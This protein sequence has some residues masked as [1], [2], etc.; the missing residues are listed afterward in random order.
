MTVAAVASYTSYVGDGV[1]TTFPY[2]FLVLDAAHLQVFVAGVATASFTV[3]GVGNPAG[4]Q[5]IFAG[6]PPLGAR[7]QIYRVMPLDQVTSYFEGDPFPA[8]AHERAL[9]RLVLQLQQLE[10]ALGRTLGVDRTAPE[11][12]RAVALPPPG[13][14]TLLGWNADGSALSTYDPAIVQVTVDPVSGRATGKT[15]RL[16]ASADGAPLLTAA[17]VFAAGS[18][19]L[20]VTYRCTTT[21]STERGLT[22]IDLGMLGEGDRWGAGVGRT[23]PTLSN[24]GQWRNYRPQPIVDLTD[25]TL[26]PRGGS[27]GAAGACTITGHWETYQADL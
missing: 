4:G 3:T 7:L 19:A 2:P 23:A 10:E 22:G 25:V 6:P 27:F 15:T 18:L 24:C 16:V 1:Q 26:T 5:V 8:L 11:A 17:G 13:A 20:G 21:F 14:L 12:L 9:D